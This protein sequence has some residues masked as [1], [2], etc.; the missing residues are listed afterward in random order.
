[1]LEEFGFGADVGV[2]VVVWILLEELEKGSS[3]FAS[4]SKDRVGG[5]LSGRGQKMMAKTAVEFGNAPLSLCQEGTPGSDTFRSLSVCG[6]RSV[7]RTVA[8]TEDVADSGGI[9]LV[10]KVEDIVLNGP[11]I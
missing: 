4:G 9:E 6:I 1:M 8:T 5:H 7:D 3:S 2:Y 10:T 11:L